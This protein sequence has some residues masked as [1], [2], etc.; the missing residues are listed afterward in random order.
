MQS[1]KAV[2]LIHQ[3]ERLTRWGEIMRMI[4]A[5]VLFVM[6]LTALADEH[7]TEGRDCANVPEPGTL[8]M[9]GAGIAVALAF[10]LKSKF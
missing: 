6:P 2:I 10:K 5:L 8:A 7:C 4:H 1:I 9:L 3:T